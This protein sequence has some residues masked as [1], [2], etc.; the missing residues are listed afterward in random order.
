MHMAVVSSTTFHFAD[1]T[2]LLYSNRSLNRLRTALNKDLAFLY[3]WLCA[4]RLSLNEGKTEFI[5]FR[6]PK[7]STNLR[8]TLR[9]HHTK[10]YESVKIKYLGLI[11]DNKLNW[12]AHITELSKKLSR[13]IGLLYKIKQYCR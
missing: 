12:R 9:L 10:L 13:G 11:L 7:R 6:P 8:I 2:N 1:D 5:V 3:D 4:N